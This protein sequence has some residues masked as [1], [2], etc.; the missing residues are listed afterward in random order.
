MKVSVDKFGA[1]TQ[2]VTIGS[3]CVI[4]ALIMAG[5]GTP[6]PGRTGSIEVQ[7]TQGVNGP[8]EPERVATMTQTEEGVKA[9]AFTLQSE[10]ISHEG[11]IPVQYTC[12]GEDSSPP[13]AWGE[14]PE[15]TEALAL[16][17]DDPDAPAGT[18]VH[19][20]IFNIPAES[21]ELAPA[22]SDDPNPPTGGIHGNNSWGRLGYGGPCPPSGT[23]RYFFK[24]YALGS[25]LDLEPGVTKDQVLQAMSGQI[26]AQ[27]ELMGTFG[28]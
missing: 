1:I 4:T 12:D 22:I 13:L 27:A 23:H 10:A 17:M 16:I 18:W 25:T 11:E 14:P 19:W 9:M 20:V 24:L 7:E 6:G 2:K 15:G 26:L 3:T 8:D 21:R 5:C 28:R